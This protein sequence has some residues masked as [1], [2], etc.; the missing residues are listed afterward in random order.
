MTKILCGCGKP[1]AGAVLCE[2]CVKTFTYAIP[3]VGVYYA[4]LDTVERKQTRYVAGG[5]SKGSIGKSQPLPVDAR[6]VGGGVGDRLRWDAWSLVNAWSRRVLREQPEQHGPVCAD[7]CLHV[8][9]ATTRRR[10]RPGHELSSMIYYLS[11]Q[12][13]WITRQVWAPEMFAAFLDLERRLSK[14]VDRPPDRWYAGKCSARDEDDGD[15]ICEAELYATVET[16]HIDCRTCGTRHDVAARRDFL[17]E[18]AKGYLVTATE[19]AS[20][21]MAWT[22]YDGSEGKLVDRIRKWR[23]GEKL[24]VQDVRSLHGRDRHLYRLGDIQDLLV[25]AAQNAQ[26]RRIARGSA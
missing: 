17:L 7:V 2:D 19:A 5:A 11:R 23:D 9:C 6:F 4:D 10:R 18:E 3:N 13:R 26:T 16:G 25:K 8:S 21:L 20:A 14:F 12:F 22:D 1:T 15:A 24:E